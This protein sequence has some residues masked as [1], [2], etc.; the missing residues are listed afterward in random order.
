MTYLIIGL[1][2]VGLSKDP[3][4]KWK[5]RSARY[6]EGEVCA[7]EWLEVLLQ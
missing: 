2:R 5:G 4:K 7:V 6:N 3:S 1:A